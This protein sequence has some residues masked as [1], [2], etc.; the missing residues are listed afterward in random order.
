MDLALNGRQYATIGKLDAFTQLH[1]ARKLAPALPIIEGLVSPANAS[2]DKQ[3][4][5]VLMLSHVSDADADYVVKKCL[6]VVARR[7]ADNQLAR[8]QSADGQLMFD[9]T[10]MSDLLELAVAVIEENMGDF[11]RTALSALSADENKKV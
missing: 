1:L 2:K 11:F 9:D 4:L 10:P 7:Q 3:V 8:L 6:G 5:V